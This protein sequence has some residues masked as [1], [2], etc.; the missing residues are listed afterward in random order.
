MKQFLFAV[1]L[2]FSGLA[3]AQYLKFS[4]N[5]NE[6]YVNHYPTFGIHGTNAYVCRL[7]TVIGSVRHSRFI[8]INL[9]GQALDT[10]AWV[11]EDTLAQ[12][13]SFDFP[14]GGPVDYSIDFTWQQGDT[15]S[16]SAFSGGMQQMKVDTVYQAQYYSNG[17]LRKTLWISATDPS[18]TW[19]TAVVEGLG[20]MTSPIWAFEDCQI[21]S[22][23]GYELRCK[24]EQG[25]RVYGAPG[26]CYIL[27]ESE[28]EIQSLSLYPNPTRNDLHI[29]GL[30]KPRDYTLYNSQ[31][32]LLLKG[33]LSPNRPLT[34]SVLP[35]GVYTLSIE[36]IEERLSF[37]KQ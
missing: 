10:L 16:I 37:C 34:I 5:S 18:C 13:L 15:F 23:V 7:D 4:D 30:D 32:A 17:P 22:E 14:V 31:G 29:D 21:I 12:T 35:N 2:F 3:Q 19:T 24:L 6:W 28:M 20:P 36:G 26:E 11:L 8:R 33:R 25:Q 9:S 27:S 1:M